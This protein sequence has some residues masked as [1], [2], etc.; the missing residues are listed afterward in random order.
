MVHFDGGIRAEESR[1]LVLDPVCV[2]LSF[3]TSVSLC[4]DCHP[5]THRRL[6]KERRNRTLLFHHQ[7]GSCQWSTVDN[8]LQ[9]HDI[10]YGLYLVNGGRSLHTSILLVQKWCLQD[11]W[12][13]QQGGY[14]C[15]RSMQLHN[16][17]HIFVC[18]Q[19]SFLLWSTITMV[20]FD[21][22][23]RAEES[24]TLVLDPV[25]VWLSLNTSILL[26]LFVTH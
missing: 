13:C 10:G 1:T 22:G 20:H 11:G 19:N 7:D 23:I 26:C 6:G 5:L 25:C 17:S 18:S 14:R 9:F 3:S 16:K 12:I 24:R 4:T 8:T 21:G 15:G 2:W